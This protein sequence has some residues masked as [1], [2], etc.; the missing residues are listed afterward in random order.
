[1]SAQVC[2][3]PGQNEVRE[4]VLLESKSIDL[5]YK[6]CLTC[7]CNVNYYKSI[8][9]PIVVSKVMIG[10]KFP[11]HRNREHTGN[12]QNKSVRSPFN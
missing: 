2:S 9:H 1:M 11:T 3:L 8:H 12:F 7:G 5:L 10:K 4:K 6:L